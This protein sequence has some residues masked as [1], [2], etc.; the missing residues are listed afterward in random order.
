MNTLK[1]WG[2]QDSLKTKTNVGKNRKGK[3]P[4]Q[5][6]KKKFHLIWLACGVRP[7]ALEQ[8]LDEPCPKCGS[9]AKVKAKT[10]D[11]IMIIC[12]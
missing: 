2:E 12:V 8:T 10:V 4:K 1:I 5:T 9:Q 3:K 11:D 6:S 7:S